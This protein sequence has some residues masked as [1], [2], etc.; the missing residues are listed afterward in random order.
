[1]N[2]KSQQSD[3]KTTFQAR[4]DKGWQR[5]LMTLRAKTGRPVKELIEDALVK[6]YAIDDKGEPYV[7]DE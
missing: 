4:I 2:M 6:T 1:M 3:K 7:I 5:I